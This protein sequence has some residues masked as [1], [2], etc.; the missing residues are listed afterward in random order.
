LFS[1]EGC[2][3]ERQDGRVSD[4]GIFFVAG[5]FVFGVLAF[6]AS[7]SAVVL[8]RIELPLLRAEA[9]ILTCCPMGEVHGMELSRI[10]DILA[11]VDTEV[12]RTGNYARINGG[13]LRRAMTSASRRTRRT[14]RVLACTLLCLLGFPVMARTFRARRRLYDSRES[15]RAPGGRGIEGFL[16][17][18]EKHLDPGMKALLSKAPT[19]ENLIDAFTQVRAKV[20]IP[21]SVVARLFGRGTRERMALLGYGKTRV[22]FAD[23]EMGRR[24]CRNGK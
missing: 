23:E 16:R 9:R 17:V 18:T 20:N 8:H 13:A 21:C 5:I 15:A 3:V 24:I 22:A 11:I 2:A 4:Q 10:E 14:E 6:L 19:P 7:R 12:A 1:K